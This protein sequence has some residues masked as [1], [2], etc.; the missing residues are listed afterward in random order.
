MEEAERQAAHAVWADGSRATLPGKDRVE[1]GAHPVTLVRS[2]ATF[3]N[4]VLVER[5]GT[6]AA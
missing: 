3:E 1:V 6:I 4:R 2:G 5:S